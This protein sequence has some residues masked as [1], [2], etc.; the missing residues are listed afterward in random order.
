MAKIQKGLS[1]ILNSLTSRRESQ[2]RR[3]RFIGATIIAAWSREFFKG[4]GRF[5]CLFLSSR[6]ALP[7]SCNTIPL[8]ISFSTVA[9]AGTWGCLAFWLTLV[10]VAITPLRALAADDPKPDPSSIEFFEKE[11]RPLLVKQ[12]MSCHGQTQQFSSL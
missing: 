7:Q 4:V 8:R 2:Y 1:R 12:C 5:F 11:V 10:L 9:G 3:Y 6:L